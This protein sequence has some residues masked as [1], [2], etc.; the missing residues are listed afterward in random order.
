MEQSESLWHYYKSTNKEIPEDLLLSKGSTSHFNVLESVACSGTL[1]FVRRDYYKICLLNNDMDFQTE[2][3]EVRIK[4]PSIIFC[5]TEK[6][7][8]VLK[9]YNTEDHH[10]YICLF[11]EGY[12]SGDIKSPL[13]RLFAL[14]TNEGYPY[15]TLSQEEFERFSKLFALMVQEYKGQFE[16]RKEVLNSLLRLVLFESI[17]IFNRKCPKV[18]MLEAE[19]RLVR[20]FMNLL[21]SQFPIDSPKNVISY[22]S[23][24]DFADKLN[25]HINHLNHSLKTGTGKSTSKLIYERIISEAID[26]LKYSDWSIADIAFSLGF[27]YPQHFSNF[28]KR[29]TGNTPRNYR[30]QQLQNI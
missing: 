14:F 15:L 18:R 28:L 23:P 5:N 24:A 8:A 7:Y 29:F 26:L 25:V 21:D 19:D 22:K 12:L 16:Y 3:G 6:K 20:S 9:K 10:G 13:N 27:E 11:N 4:G 30:K 1:P 17:K 2:E